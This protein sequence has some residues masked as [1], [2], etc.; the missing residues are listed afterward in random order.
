MQNVQSIDNETRFK[1]LQAISSRTQQA[2][3]LPTAEFKAEVKRLEPIQ[4]NTQFVPQ[5]QTAGKL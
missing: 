2:P 5:Q 1:L 3:R 4:P